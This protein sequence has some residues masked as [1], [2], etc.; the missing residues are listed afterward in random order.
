MTQCQMLAVLT[1]EDL[2]VLCCVLLCLFSVCGFRGAE[3]SAS[4]GADG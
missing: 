4:C 3:S 1:D 2:I